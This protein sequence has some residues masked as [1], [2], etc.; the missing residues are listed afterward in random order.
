MGDWESTDFVGPG[1]LAA[2][3]WEG[4]EDDTQQWMRTGSTEQGEGRERD[5]SIADWQIRMGLEQ[6]GRVNQKSRWMGEARWS[7]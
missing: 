6:G 5:W 1:L 3:D 4:M 2:A 7:R